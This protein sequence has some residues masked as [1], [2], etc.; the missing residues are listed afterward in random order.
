LLRCV[1]EAQRL[2]FKGHQE[3]AERANGT[4]LDKEDVSDS[5]DVELSPT[6]AE[7]L[8]LVQAAFDGVSTT[9][10][11]EIALMRAVVL[12]AMVSVSSQGTLCL[13]T[14]RNP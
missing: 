8:Q 4:E 12:K 9:A 14:G 10:G 3:S 13:V 1:P 11:L 7:I 6:E 5:E 2:R